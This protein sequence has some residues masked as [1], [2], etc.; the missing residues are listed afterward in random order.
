MPDLS[1]LTE[2]EL[3]ALHEHYKAMAVGTEPLE[4]TWF[5]ADAAAAAD[6]VARELRR[7]TH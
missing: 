7:R 3:R 2:T 4:S 6:R 5:R 1:T